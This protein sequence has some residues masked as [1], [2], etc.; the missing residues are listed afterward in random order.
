MPEPRLLPKHER[1][2]DATADIAHKRGVARVLAAFGTGRVSSWVVEFT[3]GA[4]AGATTTTVAGFGLTATSQISLEPITA[5]AAALLGKVWVPNA[6]LTPATDQ[7]VGSFT[8]QHPALLAGVT[9]TF[10][11]SVKG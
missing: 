4:G 7:A 8:V 2:A 3:L 11:A 1:F 10:R 9:A 6:T 5:Q